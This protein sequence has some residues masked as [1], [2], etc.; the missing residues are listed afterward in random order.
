MTDAI[1]TTATPPEVDPRS[2]LSHVAIRAQL[3]RILTHREFHATDKMRDFLRFVVEE[4]LAG[5]ASRLKGYTIATRVFARGDDFD[6]AQDPVVRIQA[7][8]LR[9]ALERYY[10]V[11]GGRDPIFIDIPKGRYIPYFSAQNA[12]PERRRSRSS[13]DAGKP[14]GSPTGPSVAVLPLVNLS[15]DPGQHFFTVGLVED[16]ATELSRFQDIAVIPMLAFI[17]LLALP[18]LQQLAASAHGGADGGHASL[19]LVDRLNAWQRALLTVGAIAFVVVVGTFLIRPIFRFIAV[20]RLRELFTATALLLVIAIALLMVLCVPSPVAGQNLLFNGSLNIGDPVEMT[21]RR[22]GRDTVL[23]MRTSCNS[24]A[25]ISRTK[26]EG[27]LKVSLPCRRRDSAISLCCR[28]CSCS[29]S[30]ACSRTARCRS[31]S[32]FQTTRLS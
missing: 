31:A 24:S 15:D 26:R 20:A 6:A 12:A 13:T 17:P 2:G 10:L 11:A 25:G 1:K 21:V 23:L 28:C 22:T 30:R 8:R 32:R 29:S 4:K 3:D 9:R 18:E 16:L 19:S 27:V 7:G 5:R 14:P